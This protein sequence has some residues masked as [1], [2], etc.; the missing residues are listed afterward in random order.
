MFRLGKLG[1]V[2]RPTP[3]MN[4]KASDH[5]VIIKYSYNK[6]LNC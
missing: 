1:S 3:Y 4:P 6:M 5:G 2:Q